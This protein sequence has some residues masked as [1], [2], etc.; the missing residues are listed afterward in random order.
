LAWNAST[1][2]T[3]YRLQVSA[4]AT[5]ATTVLDTGTLA[6]TSFVV[7]TLAQSTI[8]YWHVS[9]TNGGG[10]SAYS[11]AWS[12]TTASLPAGLLAAYAFDEGLGPTVTDK[13]GNSLTG[14]IVGATWTT[15]GKYAGAL[16]FNGTSGYVDLGNPTQLRV[17]GSMTWRR[18]TTRIWDGR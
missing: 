8:Y 11:T 9:A 4:S 1:G 10:T 17:T 13:S 6:G 2:A 12:F 3:T 7:P 16:S 18:Q 15:V 14:T 5:F